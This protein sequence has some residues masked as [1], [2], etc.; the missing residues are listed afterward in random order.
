VAAVGFAILTGVTLLDRYGPDAGLPPV[1]AGTVVAQLPVGDGTDGRTSIPEGTWMDGGAGVGVASA[2]TVRGAGPRARVWVD[3]GRCSE[4]GLPLPVRTVAAE[5]FAVAPDTF[6][7]LGLALRAGRDFLDGEGRDAPPAAIVSRALAARHFER[8]DAVGRRV[9]FGDGDW[10]T[11]V[12][13]VDD[14]PDVRDHTEY[15]VYLPLAVARPRRMEMVGPSAEALRAA[16]AAAPELAA[17]AIP[18]TTAEVFAVHGWFGGIMEALGLVCLGLVAF[19]VW[20]GARNEARATVFQVSLRKAMGARP[21]HLVREFAATAWTRLLVSLGA[22]AW[23]SLFL[24]SGLNKAYGSVPAM[25]LAVWGMAAVP[26]A[27]ALVLG[28]LPPFIRALRTHPVEGLA[29][30]E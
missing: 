7:H 4:G 9:R 27:S 14:R 13:I 26:V 23:L 6:A 16:L 17:A 18:R 30:S 5:V 19:G 11:V 24:S 2:G 8:G 29:R 12:G 10:I 3:C 1:P 20:L 28:S 21:R 22:G 25:D 15:A